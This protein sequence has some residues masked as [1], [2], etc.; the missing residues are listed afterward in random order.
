MEHID[1][2]AE[3]MEQAT[4]EIRAKVKEMQGGDGS[5]YA[6]FMGFIHAI[7]WTEPW[8]IGLI[9]VE[10]LLLLTAIIF[11][12]RTNLQTFLFFSCL[13]V[14]YLAERINKFVGARWESFARQDYFDEHGVFISAVVSGPMLFIAVV[15]LISN[16]FLMSELMIKWK[17]AELRHR[18][19][20]AKKK[21]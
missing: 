9:S 14:V 15:I 10:V 5:I 6:T 13:A 18:A 16:L 21:D 7:D 2:M 19:R 20:E 11:R 8:L 1:R 12:R 3:M 4:A 17:R